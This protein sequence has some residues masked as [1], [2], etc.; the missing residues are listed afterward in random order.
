MTGALKTL[1]CGQTEKLAVLG[2]G[3]QISQTIGTTK[4]VC[5]LLERSM[6]TLGMTCPAIN[7]STL[8]VSQV[9]NQL[10][11]YASVPS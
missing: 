2:S 7:A 1:L 9:I 4:I 5:I 8:L 3:L 6:D 10:L 11:I